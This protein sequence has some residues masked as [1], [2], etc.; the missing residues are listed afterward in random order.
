MLSSPHA[1]PR[2][3]LARREADGNY[4][5]PFHEFLRAVMLGDRERYDPSESRVPNLFDISSDDGREHF[6][7]P[8]I[9]AL[10][11]RSAEPGVSEGFVPAQRVYTYCQDLGFAPEQ[12]TWHLE[13]GIAGE[14]IEA[15]P[16]DGA[17]ELFRTGT[18]GSYIEQRLLGNLT[19]V[20][21]VAID[22]P[23]VDDITRAVIEDASFA[24][25]RIRRADRFSRYLDDQWA[26]LS[27]RETGFDWSRHGLAVRRAVEHVERRLEGG[28][29][30]PEPRPRASRK[31]RR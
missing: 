24:S 21:E 4:S 15:T 30:A 23:I 1:R 14:L 2:H 26:P 31:R 22:T 6:L 27:G 11:R 29:V 17:P 16:M 20:D 10:L 13:R 7:L 18:T 5:I 12:V 25:E 9:I 28:G 19:Y 3:A 8:I